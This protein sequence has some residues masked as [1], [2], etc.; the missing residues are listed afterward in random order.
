[1]SRITH[2][3][4]VDRIP[5]S[6]HFKDLNIILLLSLLSKHKFDTE[7]FFERFVHVVWTFGTLQLP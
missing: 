3:N 5:A 6:D 7:M 2:R 1:M 4:R